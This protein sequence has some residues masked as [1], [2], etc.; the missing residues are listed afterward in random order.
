MAYNPV[1]FSTYVFTN[2]ANAPVAG[3]VAQLSKASS[4][5]NNPSG[6]KPTT[7]T[8][9]GMSSGSIDPYIA[10]NTTMIK[11]ATLRIMGAAV[12]GAGPALNP[13]TARFDVYRNNFSTRTLISTFYINIPSPIGIFNDVSVI[14]FFNTVNDSVGITVPGGALWGVE[15]V[16]ESISFGTINNAK[17]I[18]LS[19]NTQETTL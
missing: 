17:M 13:S 12:Q 10:V 16:P 1:A 4:T 3:V 14:T 19:L 6:F 9:V 18:F 2:G 15:F 7:L 5:V 11:S 8:G